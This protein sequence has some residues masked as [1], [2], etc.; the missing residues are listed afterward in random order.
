MN[1]KKKTER[2]FTLIELLV[3]IAIIGMLSSVVLASLNGARIK[4]RDARRLADLKQVQTALELYYDSNS[5]A[6]PVSVGALMTGAV[7]GL[8]PAYIA[9]I[10]KD[11]SRADT[12]AGNAYQYCSDGQVY[13]V[14]MMPEKTG[15]YCKFANGT[16]PSTCT[17]SATIAAYPT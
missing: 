15:A 4:A 16:I 1:H 6:Y 9:S 17:N 12:I 11:P 13:A 3:V 7:S 14:I 2:G 8:A 5:S 10:P